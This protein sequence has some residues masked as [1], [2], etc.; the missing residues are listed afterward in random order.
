MGPFPGSDRR[1]SLDVVVVNEV[2]RGSYVRRLITYQSEPGSRVPAY[3]CIPKSRLH[4]ATPAPD[5]GAL[6]FGVLCLHPTDNRVGH[7]VVLG[8]GG[9]SGRAYAREL[10]ERGFVTLAPAYPLLAEY[11]PD[12]AALGYRS[13]T[14][15][16]IWDNVRALDLLASLPGIHPDRFGGIGHSLGGHNSLFT[17]FFDDRIRVIVTS[18]GFDSF[19]DYMDGDI[20][21]WTSSRYMPELAEYGPR[22]VPFDFFEVIAGLAPR[23]VFVSAPKGDTNFKWTSVHRIIET[24]RPVYRLHEAADRLEV[25]F[26]ECGHDFPLALRERAYQFLNRHLAD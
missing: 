18:C 22:Q 21:G 26:P 13:G 2:D 8:L 12:L 1:C 10:A 17:A 16:A 25:E 19:R 14:M 7:K 15:K 24:A 6:G 3:L 23:A 5:R 11:Q 20:T 9:K 4:P